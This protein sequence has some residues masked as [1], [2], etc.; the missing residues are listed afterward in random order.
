[1]DELR[2]CGESEFRNS[3][4]RQTRTRP[5][6]CVEQ[7]LTKLNYSR[8][9]TTTRTILSKT[10]AQITISVICFLKRDTQNPKIQT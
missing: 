1:M 5:R 8:T 3:A 10:E 4:L 9:R 6:R 2:S 7:S